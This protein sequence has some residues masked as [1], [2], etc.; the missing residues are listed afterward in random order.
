MSKSRIW[1]LPTPGHTAGVFTDET[2]RRLLAGFDVTENS[3][4]R[5]L[6]A[7]EVEEGIAGFR[8][9]GHRLG[10]PADQW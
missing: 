5:A 1:Y 7:A 2:Y 3:T 8:R 10:R 9:P 4:D 6:T